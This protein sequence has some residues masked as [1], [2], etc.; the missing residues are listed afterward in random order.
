MSSSETEKAPLHPIERTLISALARSGINPIK[1]D[2]IASQSSLSLDQV[3]RG[4]EWL[5][6]KKL[7]EIEE[8]E[9]RFF[10]L[11]I[12]G[13]KDS[14]AFARK[15]GVCPT[16]RACLQNRRFFSRPWK[17]KTKRLGQS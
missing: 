16:K 10:S 5:R 14:Q 17:S 1:I 12:E 2:E 8:K 3:R 13:K 9:E 4:L 11:D 15:R 6:S 7:V